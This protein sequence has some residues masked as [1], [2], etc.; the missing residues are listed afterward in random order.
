MIFGDLR[1]HFRLTVENL[2]SFFRQYLIKSLLTGFY[3]SKDPLKLILV[4]DALC[5]VP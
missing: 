2:I 5:D 1:A 4:N 3:D